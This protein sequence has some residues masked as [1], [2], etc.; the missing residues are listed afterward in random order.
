MQTEIHV[1][2][3]V[4]RFNRDATVTLYRDTITK[5]GADDCQCSSCRNF[6][7]QRTSVYPKEFLE[8]L[9]RIGA[10]PHKELE[11]FDLGPS[12]DDSPLRLYGG[13]FVFCG[14]IADGVNWRP[15]H[16]PE[17]FTYWVTDSFPS[18]GLP[19]GVCAV[20]FLCELPWVIR[21]PQE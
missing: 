9:E 6:A 3:Q 16:K 1:G 15:E 20:E 21:E 4:A 14:T 17:S 18:G 12:S 5:S 2:P 13:W 11:A 19:D 10:D 8:L 7:Q